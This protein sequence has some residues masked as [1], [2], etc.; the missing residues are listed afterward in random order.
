MTILIVE[1]EPLIRMALSEFLESRGYVC[2]HAAT[3]DNALT[4][5]Q[6]QTFNAALLDV[7]LKDGKVY[8]VVRALQQKGVRCIFITG[9]LPEE[10]PAE[11]ANLRCLEKPFDETAVIDAIAGCGA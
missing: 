7:V 5:A 8:P 9:H 11:F 2:A 4:I 6:T 3:V 1:D 10:L